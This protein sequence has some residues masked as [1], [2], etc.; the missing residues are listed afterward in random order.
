[1][2]RIYRLAKPREAIAK[3]KELVKARKIR[4]KTT[5]KQTQNHLTFCQ[6]PTKAAAAEADSKPLKETS[7]ARMLSSIY[8]YALLILVLLA[9]ALPLFVEEW[10]ERTRRWKKPKKGS[11]R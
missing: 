1:M 10:L 3:D 8:T 5:P 9:T 11:K 6:D 7:S 2:L 4:R